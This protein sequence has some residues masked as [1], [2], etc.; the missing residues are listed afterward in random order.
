MILFLSTLV[1][2][3]FGFGNAL[4]AMPLL[5]LLIGVGNA[6]PLV[7]LGGATVSVW[8]LLESWRQVNG[9]AAWRLILSTML[10]IPGGLLL[11]KFAPEAVAKGLLGVVLVGFSLYSLL[12]F[13]LPVLRNER[14]SYLFG[15]V[16]GILGGAYNANGPPV[17]MY[18]VMRK[19]PPAQF[20]ATLQGYFLITGAIILVSHSLAG[21]WTAEVLWLYIYGLPA[22]VAGLL[23]GGWVHKRIP[24]E[25]FTSAVNL[26]LL[27]MGITLLLDAVADMRP[28]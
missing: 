20:R 27:L 22:I 6:T 7:A 13:Q 11:L 4:V 5:V 17:V 15:L 26:F 14:W 21:M 9:R 16:A 25:Q 12:R 18:G 28:A 23:I 2:S 8:I 10:G 3:A 1:R 19:W 24:G